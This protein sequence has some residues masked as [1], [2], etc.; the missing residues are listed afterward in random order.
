M[1]ELLKRRT[2]AA[3][4]ALNR[5]RSLAEARNKAI[6]NESKK[7]REQKKRSIVEEFEKLGQEFEEELRNEELL[8]P[9][10]RAL[11]KIEGK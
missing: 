2:K 10:G 8:S 11:Q 1:S 3:I 4:P 7:R 5:I 6:E 9:T